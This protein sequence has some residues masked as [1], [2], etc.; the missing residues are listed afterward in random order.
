VASAQT[1]TEIAALHAQ[2]NAGDAIA[3]YNLGVAY[4]NGQSVPQDYVEAVAWY[5]KAAD[6]GDPDAQY[7]LGV[8]HDTGQGV[9]QDYVEA[10]AW[11][12]KAADQG[13]ANAQFNLGVSYAIG[14]GVPQDYVETH[15]WHNLAAFRTS[16][17]N[18]TKYAE[19][20]DRVANLMTPTQI[21]DAQRLAR[22][23]Q[24]TFDARQE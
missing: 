15:K 13:Y 17:E 18:Q 23:W 11:Y 20:R 19:D 8:M 21:A 10:A 3:Q 12:R 16:A 5:R 24:A 6:Q 22:E 4:D 2:A 14:Q 9:P 7:N 1:S